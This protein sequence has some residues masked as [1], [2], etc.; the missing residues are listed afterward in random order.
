MLFKAAWTLDFVIK[1]IVSPGYVK[2]HLDS[3][4]DTM[5]ATDWTV[6]SFQPSYVRRERQ[7]APHAT[8]DERA[9]LFKVHYAARLP[10]S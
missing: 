5:S 9:Q 8:V 7:P 6:P 3:F 10:N 4:S 2:P 1:R